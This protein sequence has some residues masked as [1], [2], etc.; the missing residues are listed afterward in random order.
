[1][2]ARFRFPLRA[3]EQAARS[4]NSRSMARVQA[5]DRSMS[6]SWAML[7]R[8]SGISTVTFA[9]LP[10]IVCRRLIARISYPITKGNTAARGG[11]KGSVPQRT[12]QP[13][14]VGGWLRRRGREEGVFSLH[15]NGLA[16]VCPRPPT[17][18]DR[19]PRTLIRSCDSHPSFPEREGVTD[20]A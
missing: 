14:V 16:G 18:R 8:S 17:A 1:M 11:A 13:A 5:S 7:S 12:S 4:R 3:K 2:L 15:S 10:S 6:Y 20:A 19:A 9:M